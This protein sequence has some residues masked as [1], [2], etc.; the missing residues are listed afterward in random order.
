M[1]LQERPIQTVTLVSAVQAALRARL[2]QY[3]AAR[4]LAEREQAASH[5]EELVGERTR[6]L[7]EAND[8]LTAAQES[9]TMALEAAQMRTWNLDLA[10]SGVRDPPSVTPSRRSRSL[11]AEME[12]QARSTKI[13][14]EDEEAF[15]TAFRQALDT[16]R[17]NLECPGCPA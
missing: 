13:L 10:G 5:L 15:E 14:P 9:L 2:R 17:F 4:Y 7:Q 11:L 3:E 12:P 6:Q 1:T 16:G 8:H